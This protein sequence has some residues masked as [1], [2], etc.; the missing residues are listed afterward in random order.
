MDQ[1]AENFIPYETL[2]PLLEDGMTF[3]QLLER[4]CALVGLQPEKYELRTPAVPND[5][6][7][8]EALYGGVSLIRLGR[9]RPPGGRSGSH[10]P[11]R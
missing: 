9:S 8:R 11:V 2:E 4:V 5:L 3:V 6:P 7:L 10:E 1:Q